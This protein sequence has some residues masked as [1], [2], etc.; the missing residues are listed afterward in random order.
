MWKK[1][2][3][4]TPR[5]FGDSSSSSGNHFLHLQTPPYNPIRSVHKDLEQALHSLTTP[6]LIFLQQNETHIP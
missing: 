1:G 6:L 5:R 3:V 4:D 2:S